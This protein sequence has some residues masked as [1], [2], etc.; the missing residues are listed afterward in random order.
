MEMFGKAVDLDSTDLAAW[1]RLGEI[2]LSLG[3]VPEARLSFERAAYLAPE[4]VRPLLGLAEALA[5]MGEI[6]DA[7]AVTDRALEL[8]P[9]SENVHELARRLDES[10]Q[11]AR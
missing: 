3:R 9:D 11:E 4:L 2:Q 5:R 1:I 8:E 6:D 10:A 7:R